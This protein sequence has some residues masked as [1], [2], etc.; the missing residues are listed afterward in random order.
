MQYQKISS[1]LGTTKK[2]GG[3]LRFCALALVE[4]LDYMVQ[5]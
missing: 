3:L 1:D 4:L 5:Y 2:G